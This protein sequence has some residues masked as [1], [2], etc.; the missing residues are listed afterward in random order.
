MIHITNGHIHW[1]YH[2]KVYS[3]EQNA[4]LA[5]VYMVR[6]TRKIPVHMWTLKLNRRKGEPKDK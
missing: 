4:S 2:A 5:V 3:T 1:T 6:N